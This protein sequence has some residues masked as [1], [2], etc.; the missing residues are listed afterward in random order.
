[1]SPENVI[2]VFNSLGLKANV[3]GNGM[4]SDQDVEPGKEVEKGTTINISTELIGD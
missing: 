4:V 3:H 2:S 1:M